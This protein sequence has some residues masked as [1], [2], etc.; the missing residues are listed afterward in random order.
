M[1]IDG[2]LKMDRIKQ[3]VELVE[4]YSERESKSVDIV[5][6]KHVY[7]ECAQELTANEDICEAGYDLRNCILEKREKYGVR[8]VGE[9]IWL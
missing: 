7:E 9:S 4:Q 6:L 8:N 3:F 5:G 2:T 1:E